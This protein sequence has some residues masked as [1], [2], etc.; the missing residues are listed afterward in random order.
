VAPA[1]GRGF[2]GGGGRGPAEPAIPTFGGMVPADPGEYTVVITAG[3]KTI[4]KTV[5]V[6][7]DV[8]FDKVF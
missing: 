4:S 8:W 6:L 3:G 2:G 5:Q 7:D 1:R